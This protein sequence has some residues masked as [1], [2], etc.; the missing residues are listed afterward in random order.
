MEVKVFATVFITTQYI[1][2]ILYALLLSGWDKKIK[3]QYIGSLLLIYVIF[4]FLI[5]I[6]L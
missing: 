4:L 5:W 3:I 6:I 1:L 2:Y